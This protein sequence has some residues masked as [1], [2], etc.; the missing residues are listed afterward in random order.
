MDIKYDVPAP[1]AGALERTIS[2]GQK[3]MRNTRYAKMPLGRLLGLQLAHFSPLYWAV[4]LVVIVCILLSTS[5]G[6]ESTRFAVLVYA[7]AANAL[8][9]PELLRDISC[10]MSEI[11]RSCRISGAKLLAA[12]MLIIA[13]A[14]LMG[15]TLTAVIVSSKFGTALALPLIMGAALLFSS[16]FLTLLAL[17]LLPFVRSRA[18]ALSLSLVI[19]AAL[20]IVCL[21][22][23]WSTGVWALACAVSLVLLAVQTWHELSDIESRKGKSIWNYL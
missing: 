17:R 20:G 2:L 15:L 5:S 9:C 7:G 22:V 12:R 23:V 1:P 10:S 16:S 6:K 8:G 11:E 14:D 19:S 18:G 13:C 3:K 4:Q 21:S